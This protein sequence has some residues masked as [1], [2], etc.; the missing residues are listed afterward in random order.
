M[1]TP[2]EMH[3]TKKEKNLKGIILLLADIQLT[4]TNLLVTKDKTETRCYTAHLHDIKHYFITS[5]F[6]RKSHN[7]CN[8]GLERSS[9]VSLTSIM[10]KGSSHCSDNHC[11]DNYCSDNHC[12]DNHCSDNHCSDIYCSNDHCSDA[13]NDNFDIQ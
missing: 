6:S 8:V 7:V 11:S 10:E 2:D 9:Q 12:S 4:F 1:D 5:S 3:I 13:K